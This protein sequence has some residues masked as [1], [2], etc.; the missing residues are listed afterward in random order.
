VSIELV[1]GRE[2]R[3]GGCYRLSD[4]GPIHVDWLSELG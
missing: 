1:G 2:L 3:G 4:P